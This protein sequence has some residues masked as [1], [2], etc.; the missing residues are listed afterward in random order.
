MDVY[1]VVK[2]LFAG[3]L[4]IHPIATFFHVGLLLTLGAENLVGDD[5]VVPM[6]FTCLKNPVPERGPFGFIVGVA[7]LLLLFHNNAMNRQEPFDDDASDLVG[8]V[9]N[10]N[11][12]DL[13]LVLGCSLIRPLVSNLVGIPGLFRVA[14]AD[15]CAFIQVCRNCLDD[16]FLED[17]Y[18][19]IMS[20]G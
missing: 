12:L 5:K 3:A 4:L 16:L 14:H 2:E 17:P 18:F 8:L 6:T 1:V 9:S 15:S 11:F 13:V 20:P 7:D 10:P 19:T